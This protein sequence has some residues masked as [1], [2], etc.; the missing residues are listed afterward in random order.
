M[1]LI[2]DGWDTV[3]CIASGPSLTKEQVDMVRDSGHKVIAVSN[4]YQLIPTCDV[5]YSADSCWWLHFYTDAHS[6]C[7]SKTEFWTSNKTIHFM[8]KTYSRLKRELLRPFYGV[9]VELKGQKINPDPLTINHGGNS[10]F[11]AVS[12]A[13][14]FGAKK[15]ILIGYDFQHTGGKAHWFGDHDPKKLRINAA[16]SHWWPRSFSWL[17]EDLHNNGT[18]VLNATIETA[19]EDTEH[20]PRVKLEEVL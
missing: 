15:I 2:K 16:N 17:T 10:G 12:L 13:H 18:Q 1:N 20:C 7:H 5:L 8:N 3:V 11:M 4:N 9:E 14:K 19:I 6:V